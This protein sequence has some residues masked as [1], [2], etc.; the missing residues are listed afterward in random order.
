MSNVVSLKKSTIGDLLMHLIDYSFRIRTITNNSILCLYF[1]VPDEKKLTDID[2]LNVSRRITDKFTIMRLGL[3]LELER[4]TL[5]AILYDNKHSIRE[6]A[7]RMISEWLKT[8]EDRSKAH[9]KLLT[10]LKHPDVNL[11]HIAHEVFR[12]STA[13]KNP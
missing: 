11:H 2:S 5:E 10:V 13:G 9:N 6:A 8:Q 12:A 1:Q 3:H 4:Y 7:Y